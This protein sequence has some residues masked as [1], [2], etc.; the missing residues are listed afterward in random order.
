MIEYLSSYKD[1]FFDL[2]KHVCFYGA[3]LYSTW[4]CKDNLLSLVTIPLLGLMGMRNFI[5]F[6]DCGHN[7]YTP[8]KELNYILGTI[9]SFI[10][11]TPYNWNYI[12]HNHHLTSGNKTNKY[13]HNFNETILYTKQ[14]YESLTFL[15][16]YLYRIIRDPLIFYTIIPITK[17]IL[18]NK[19]EMIYEMIYID[20]NIYKYKQ[21][22]TLRLKNIIINLIGDS[23]VFYYL[24]YLNILYHFLFSFLIGVSLGFMLFHNQHTY[25]PGY[26]VDDKNWNKKDSG[27]K[28]SSF[29]QVPEYLKYFTMGI[30]YHHVHHMN[31]KIPGYNLEIYHAENYKDDETITKLSMKDCYDNLWLTLYDEK[32]KKYI[33]F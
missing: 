19:I 2:C 6:H 7:S 5:I 20:D 17:F 25:N 27:L 15:H 21:T 10:V 13:N 32:T 29:I 22:K 16:K 4:Y 3:C 26:I 9:F 31:A 28:G 8:N 18:M 12:H 24:N 14:E 11:F 23:I 33:S 30:E 1:S